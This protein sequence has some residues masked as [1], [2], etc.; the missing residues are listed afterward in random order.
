MNP[1]QLDQRV[2]IERFTS[3]Q[4]ELGQPVQAWTPLCTV[5]AAVEP[6]AGRE[7]VA[8]GAAQS[9]LTTKIRIRYLSG[10]TS[11]DRVT[12]EGKVYDIQSVIDYRS[13]GR[14]IVLMC[15]G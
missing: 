13:A 14:E 11:G 12:H 15:K 4:D 9:E 8:A 3:E 7:F 1:G 2:S 6:Q 10:I 5:W